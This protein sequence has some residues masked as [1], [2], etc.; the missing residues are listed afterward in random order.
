MP[1]AT[2]I[3]WAR[4]LETEASERRRLLAG[5]DELEAVREPDPVDDS[6]SAIERE[7]RAE[8]LSRQREILGLVEEAQARLADGTFGLCFDCSRPIR[9]GRL[10]AIPWA[11]RCREC[12]E[13]SN[14]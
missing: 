10:L 3:D 12:E 1:T 14:V 2:R 8:F 5:R 6:L 13:Q 4:I 9:E 11:V 7:D